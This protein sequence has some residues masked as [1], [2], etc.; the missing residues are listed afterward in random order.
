[1]RDRDAE[2]HTIIQQNTE[3]LQQQLALARENLEHT[4]KRNREDKHRRLQLQMGG[5][6]PGRG[7]TEHTNVSNQRTQGSV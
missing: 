3:L 7:D 4:K 6:T 2:A 1:M 5:F